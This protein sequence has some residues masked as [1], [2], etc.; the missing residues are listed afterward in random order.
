MLASPRV[1]TH[2]QG[3][4]DKDMPRHSS[5]SYVTIREDGFMAVEAEAE[6]EFWTVPLELQGDRLEL[7]AWT[8]FGGKVAVE[9]CDEQGKP[10]AGY[11]LAEALPLSGDCLFEQ[12]AFQG[13]S[14]LAALKGRSVRLHFRLTR[15][16]LYSFRSV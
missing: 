12:A 5:L 15:A 16:R 1:S 9:V 13:H 8:H 10:I 3:F 7:N 11:S 6:G 4:Y 14:D 2:N